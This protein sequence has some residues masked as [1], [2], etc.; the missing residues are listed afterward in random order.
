[1]GC[2]AI[3][4][5][6]CYI[7]NIDED[8]VGMTRNIVW[9]DRIPLDDMSHN[10]LSL[11]AVFDHKSMSCYSELVPSIVPGHPD[12]LKKLTIYGTRISATDSSI[13]I[14]YDGL[15]NFPYDVTPEA[16]QEIK[17]I[18]QAT[19]KDSIDMETLEE[20]IFVPLRTYQDIVTGMVKNIRSHS[21]DVSANYRNQWK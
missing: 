21:R 12:E 2:W 1:M 13:R 20:D 19:A 4:A 16:M 15:L 8:D 5:N 7:A 18:M 3:F 17:K 9:V 11:Q 14:M 6:N 10:S